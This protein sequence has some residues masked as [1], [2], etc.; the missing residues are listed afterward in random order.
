MKVTSAAELI[1]LVA[2]KRVVVFGAGVHRRDGA[3]G[4]E[5]PAPRDDGNPTGQLLVATN[6]KRI[7]VR[8]QMLVSDEHVVVEYDAGA[9][10]EKLE[11]FEASSEAVEDFVTNVGLMLLFPYMRQGVA[12]LTQRV[13]HTVSLGLVTPG[14]LKIQSLDDSVPLPLSAE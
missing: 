8:Y 13:G 11:S 9:V 1:K 12:D 10:F 4:Q 6:D 7:T 3:L 2:F 14:S 5:L